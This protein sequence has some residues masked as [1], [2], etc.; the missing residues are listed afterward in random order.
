M[1]KRG[2]LQIARERTANL[3]HSELRLLLLL[4]VTALGMFLF[5]HL[6]SEV[7]DGDTMSFDRAVLLALRVPGHVTEPIGPHWLRRVMMQ[8]TALG[9]RTNL[10]LVTVL[11]GAYLVV[12][13]RPA[14][15]A[16]LIGAVV[17]GVILSTLLKAAF[18]RPRPDIIMHLV[19]AS[20]PSFPSGHALNSSVTYLTLGALLAKAER[21][22]MVR[23]YVVSTAILLT[24][25]IGC[26]RIYLGVHW[27]TDIL[28]GWCV[29]SAWALACS[30][31]ADYVQ[32]RRSPRGSG[33]AADRASA[34]VDEI[35]A[36]SCE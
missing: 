7:V 22:R 23:I 19:A 34:E 8:I 2:I 27:P 21:S 11:V 32:L 28:A 1:A 6:A 14:T 30:L 13:K 5:F 29:G 10:T 35:E 20:S 9:G 15:A 12:A 3:S 26:S 31:A 33:N 36:H 17:G 4:A 24:V 18:D 25:L 16:F